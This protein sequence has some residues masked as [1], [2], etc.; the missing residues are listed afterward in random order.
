MKYMIRPSKFLLLLIFAFCSYVRGMEKQKPDPS[1][2]VWE[3]KSFFKPE[4]SN[5]SLKETGFFISEDRFFTHSHILIK[6]MDHHFEPISEKDLKNIV[7]TQEGSKRVLRI[8][9]IDALSFVDEAVIFKTKEK[10]KHFLPIGE[11]DF[12]VSSILSY[13]NGQLVK[14]RKTEKVSYQKGENSSFPV[15]YTFDSHMIGSP[16]LNKK[17]QVFSIVFDGNTDIIDTIRIKKSIF[18]KPYRSINEAIQELMRSAYIGETRAQHVLAKIYLSS[19]NFK[20]SLFWYK[21]AA[22][23]GYLYALNGLAEMYYFGRGV[24]RDFKEAVSWYEKAAEQGYA[25]AS[26]SLAEMYYFAH[27]IEVD[28]KKAIFWYKKAAEQGY[29]FASNMLGNIYINK[30]IEEA[31]FW[32]EKAAEQG[33]PSAQ[34][35]IRE[36]KKKGIYKKVKRAFVSRQKTHKDLSLE[37][38]KICRK[39]FQNKSNK[40]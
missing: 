23:Q 38:G 8:E 2:S 12:K 10:V 5:K 27:G 11:K 19:K 15:N 3:V 39:Y 25:F 37:K 28:M 29:A 32:Y 14:I 26:N 24:E 33:Y 21:K 13:K 1:L 18:I 34:E 30:D 31:L 20:E 40:M 17:K 6:F 35:K 22:E 7:L 36:Y 9:S 16:V 4:L